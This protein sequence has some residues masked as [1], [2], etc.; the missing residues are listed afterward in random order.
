MHGPMKVKSSNI[1]SKWQM[2][3]NSAFKGLRTAVGQGLLCEVPRSY[4]DTA[5]SVRFL[6]TSDRVGQGLLCEVPRSYSDTAHSVRLL[7]TSD[8]SDVV[9]CT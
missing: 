8:R 2:R 6:K 5:H 4:S 7:K 3:F 9:I 1:T